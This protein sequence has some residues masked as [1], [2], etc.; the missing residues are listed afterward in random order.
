MSMIWPELD[1]SPIPTTK[2]ENPSLSPLG[3]SLPMTGSRICAT[4]RQ[5]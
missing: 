1:M 2:L 4:N 3:A 5:R